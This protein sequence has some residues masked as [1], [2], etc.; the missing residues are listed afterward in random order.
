MDRNS[1]VN[2]EFQKVMM[3]KFDIKDLVLMHY[4]LGIKVYQ[5]ND[6]T[7]IFQTKYAND[8]LIKV[9]N[10]FLLHGELLRKDD[11]SKKVDVTTTDTTQASS[12][13]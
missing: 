9:V 1:K 4:L 3:N 10:P 6:E 12:T 2:D 5:N 8:M 13:L 7:F 11:G